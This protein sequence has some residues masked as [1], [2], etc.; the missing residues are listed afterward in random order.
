VNWIVHRV[1]I[2][3]EYDDG[4]IDVKTEW[5]ARDLVDAHKVLDVCDRVREKESP[6]E[7]DMKPRNPSPPNSSIIT[8]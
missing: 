6:D 1:A 4:L 7:N 5:S 3:D 8:P 2:S